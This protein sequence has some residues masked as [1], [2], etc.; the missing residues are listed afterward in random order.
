[1][2]TSYVTRLV[3][4]SS[5]DSQLCLLT[6]LYVVFAAATYMLN[7]AFKELSITFCHDKYKLKKEKTKRNNN[8]KKNQK[9][10][11]LFFV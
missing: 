8:K 4:F 7:Y 2:R 3:T 9:N 1:M 6:K 5:L 11:I 10:K